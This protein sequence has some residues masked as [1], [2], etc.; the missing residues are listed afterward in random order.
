MLRNVVLAGV[1]GFAVSY[2]SA[3]VYYTAENLQ[4]MAPDLTT[5][6]AICVSLAYWT[7]RGTRLAMNIGLSLVTSVV[8]A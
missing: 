3:I 4:Q 5:S 6:A 8:P 2:V 1:A 7:M